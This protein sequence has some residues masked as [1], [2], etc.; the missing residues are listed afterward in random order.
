MKVKHFPIFWDIETTGL[1]PMI[2]PWMNWDDPAHITAIAIGYI[3]DWDEE[4]EKRKVHCIMNEGDAEYELIEKARDAARAIVTKYALLEELNAVMVGWNIYQFDAPYW[5]ARC[6]RLRQN[7]YPFGWGE[8]RLD[9]MRALEF[10]HDHPDG[11]KKHPGQQDYADWLGIDYLDEL[12]GDQMPEA[13]FNG[14]YQIIKD[15]VIDDVKVAMEIF[16][17]ERHMCL[18]ELYSHYDDLPDNPPVLGDVVDLSVEVD[19][20][21]GA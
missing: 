14:D 1:N 13:F 2:E 20:I 15:H 18:K 21:D 19:E 12:S 7:P 10:G 11:P 4:G 5:S 8:R 6:G 17:Q 3:E 16:M 9:M